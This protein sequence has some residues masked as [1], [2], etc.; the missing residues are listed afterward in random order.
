MQ[1][2]QKNRRYLKERV[3]ETLGLLYADHFPYRQVATGARGAALAAAR[4]SEGARRGVRRGGR[5]GARQLVR[6]S[7]GPGARISLFLEAAELVRQPARRASGGAHGVGLFD[8]TSFGKI[9]V[10]GRDALRL[11][12][13]HLRQRWTSRPERSSTPDAERARRHRSDLTVTRLSETAFFLVVPG[14]TLAA[15][16]RLAA[17]RIS[18][19]ISPSS[20]M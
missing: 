14:A 6:E 2:F 12:A 9:R 17:P 16:P 4:A 8:M 1:P 10:E 5:L 20:P 18:A 3:S 15:R 13:P 19:T 7:E 11:P